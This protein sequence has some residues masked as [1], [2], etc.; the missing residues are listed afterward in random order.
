MSDL[1]DCDIIGAAGAVAPQR[2]DFRDLNFDGD[3][4]VAGGVP[5]R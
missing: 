5:W 4:G 1:E 3:V 2:P